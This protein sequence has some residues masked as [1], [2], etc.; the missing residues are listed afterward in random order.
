M[1]RLQTLPG[2]MLVLALLGT[3][4]A[5]PQG[6]AQ[7]AAHKREPISAEAT[8]SCEHAARQ[9]LNARAGLTGAAVDVSFG[10]AP[11]V[12]PGLSNDERVVL[13]GAGRARGAAGLRSFSYSC[14][15]D[16]R[17]GDAIGLVLR[18]TTAASL[19]EPEPARAS[20]DDPDLSSLSP[21]A[22]ETSAAEALQR[23]WPRITGISFEAS[24]RS[25]S[26]QSSSKAELHGSGRALPAPGGVTKLFVFDCQI[27]PRDGHV[28]RTN[29]SG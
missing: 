28:L 1:D 24:T 18:D 5:S 7:A 12:Q 27:D 13:R 19:E 15:V 3:I 8:A 6:R 10:P 4:A 25:F 2:H 17:T 21:E 23:R 29:I 14:N 26:Q 11:T 22:C 20:W 9:T 16:L